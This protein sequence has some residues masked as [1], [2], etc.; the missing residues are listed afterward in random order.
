MTIP[1]WLY[2][3]LLTF[4]NLLRWVVVI[5][6]AIAL[7]RA[8]SGWLAKRAFTTSDARIW[9]LFAGMF[10][11]QVLLGLMLYFAPGTFTYTAFRNFG[12]AMGDEVTRFFAIEH[13]L[14]MLISL[15]LVHVGASKAKKAGEDNAKHRAAALWFSAAFLILFLAIPW[16]PV[17]FLGS[18]RPLLRLFGLSLP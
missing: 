15:V 14:M 1:I 5:L 10:D 9:T 7:V 12:A 17:S 3:T 6:A 11:V 16:S 13:I 18:E 2:T 4:H 8:W